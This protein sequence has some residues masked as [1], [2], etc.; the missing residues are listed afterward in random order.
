MPYYRTRH[1]VPMGLELELRVEQH[2]GHSGYWLSVANT[3][4]SCDDG[5]LMGYQSLP[6][7]D[8]REMSAAIAAVI[9]K[10]EREE[11]Q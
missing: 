3:E 2:T 8:L 1:T 11:Q 7:E 10:L 4:D 5:E 9:R 6:L